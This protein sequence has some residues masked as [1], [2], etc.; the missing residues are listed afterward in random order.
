MFLVRMKMPGLMLLMKK[1]IGTRKVV[2]RRK[3]LSRT[4]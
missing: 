4:R 1:V 3:T 2:K